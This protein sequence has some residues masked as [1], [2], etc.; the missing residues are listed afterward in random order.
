MLNQV[1]TVGVGG[2]IAIPPD[3]CEKFGV[4]VGDKI[5][6]KFDDGEIRLSSQKQALARLMEKMQK[7]KK[8]GEDMV[9]E[10]LK[11]RKEDWRL[12]YLTRIV[13]SGK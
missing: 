4:S 10:F 2:T 7:L 8:P 6:M 13:A 1:V 5:T 11:F 9:D 12:G 3:Y